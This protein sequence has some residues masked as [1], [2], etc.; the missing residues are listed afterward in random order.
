MC[1]EMQKSNGKW[2]EMWNNKNDYYWNEHNDNRFR[3]EQVGGF[4]ELVVEV[5]AKEYRKF[6]VDHRDSQAAYDVPVK[7][8]WKDGGD[9]E[10]VSNQIVVKVKNTEQESKCKDATLAFKSVSRDLSMAW[11]SD[12]SQ[13]EDGYS[14]E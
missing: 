3:I 7:I 14:Q 1:L 11:N 13:S 8:S 10:L 2:V 6:Q 9:N 5:S 12:N 4:Y